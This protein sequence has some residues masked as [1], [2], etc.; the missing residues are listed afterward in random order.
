MKKS[1]KILIIVLCLI[2]V[3]LVTF[4]VVDKVINKKVETPQ[5]NDE[6]IVNTTSNTNK[7]DNSTSNESDNN[8]S[9]PEDKK[10]NLEN[11]NTL[12]NQIAVQNDNDS[13]NIKDSEYAKEYIKI[14][15]NIEKDKD[16]DDIT[17]DLIYFNNDNIP[18]LVIG[19]PG[20]WVS[21]YI[22]EDGNV[23]NLI[24]D[25]A[26]GVMGNA[27][28]SYIEKKGIILN[29][30]SDFAGA[31]SID[32][33]LILNSKNEFDGLHNISKGADIEKT[34]PMY[35]DVQKTL[36]ETEGYSYNEETIS[37]QEYNDKLKE[38]SIN[39]NDYS[40]SKILEGSQTTA[41]LKKQLK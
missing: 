15:D 39:P 5:S 25:W 36:A 12:Q 17:C 40:A 23:Y 18:D 22:Y 14:I 24:D 41:E 2:I 35:E 27:G 26:Y 29:H 6:K 16:S 20:Y 33:I 1:V 7:T 19:N 8:S 10:D 32:S 37:E 34:D 9:I 21:L 3:G 4:I 28:Y 31:I 38:L 11:S 13:L 30:N